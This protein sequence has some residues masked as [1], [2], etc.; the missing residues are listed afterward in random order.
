MILNRRISEL[1]GNP[2]EPGSPFSFYKEAQRERKF[3]S[4]LWY[5]GFQIWF[6]ALSPSTPPCSPPP[7]PVLLPLTQHRKR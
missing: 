1:E 4:S 3:P 6:I 7:F 2:G 5:L